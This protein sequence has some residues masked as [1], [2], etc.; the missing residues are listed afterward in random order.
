MIG[1][2]VLVS[3]TASGRY[4]VDTLSECRSSARVEDEKPHTW[5]GRDKR[6]ILPALGVLAPHAA[7]RLHDE[8]SKTGLGLSHAPPRQG[9]AMRSYLGGGMI[10]S[11]VSVERKMRLLNRQPEESVH[12]NPLPV[13]CLVI[14]K[15]CRNNTD[16][17]RCVYHMV[18]ISS[19][20]G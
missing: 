6:Y 7:G 13:S 2:V 3:C 4:S 8:G 10:R 15:K 18:S 1:L 17:L 9:D 20:K 16:T 12:D 19:R 14:S 11:E 5:F